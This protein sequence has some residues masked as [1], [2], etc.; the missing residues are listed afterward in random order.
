MTPETF[1]FSCKTLWGDRWQAD[2]TIV[3]SVTRRSLG[4]WT[5]GKLPI[6]GGVVE[7]LRKALSDKEWDCKMAQHKISEERFK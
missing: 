6:P 7:T 3:L 4:N 2:A 1:R 5:S